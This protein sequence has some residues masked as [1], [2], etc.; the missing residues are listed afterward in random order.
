MPSGTFQIVFP[1]A[2]GFRHREWSLGYLA[3]KAIQNLNIYVDSSR[4]ALIAINGEFTRAQKG[5]LIIS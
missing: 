1:E 4:K 2:R 5:I 3:K